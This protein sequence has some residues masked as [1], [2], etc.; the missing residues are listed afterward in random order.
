MDNYPDVLV[1][2]QNYPELDADTV[3]SNFFIRKTKEDVYSY[4]KKYKPSELIDKI[5]PNTTRRDVFVFSVSL[6]GYYN[7]DHISLKVND[8]SLNQEWNRTMPNFPIYQITY[9][10]DPGHPL[11]LCAK[12]LYEHPIIFENE[13]F[14]LSFW[15]KPTIVNY[16]HFQLFTKDSSG[17]HLPREPKQGER[18]TKTEE[19]K[20]KRL[21]ATVLEYLIT[22]SICPAS[23]VTKFH[24]DGIV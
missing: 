23:E 6:Y 21:A 1:S 22:E 4:L 24:C 7:E 10:I 17:E 5:L 11:F 19:R 12:K 18:E 8:T 16:W 3:S 2:Q 13:N 9:S 15:H 20:L 14:Y